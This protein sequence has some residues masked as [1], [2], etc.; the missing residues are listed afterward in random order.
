M[1][2]RG[3]R[4]KKSR[5]HV[6]DA[7]NVAGT[8]DNAEGSKVPK[9]LVIRRG[10]C[11]QVVGDLIQDMRRLMMPYTA[12]NF[13]ED[14]NYRKLTLSKYCQ[15]VC[16]PLGISHIMAFSQ[17]DERLSL[18]IA[19]TPQGPTLTFRVHLFSLTKHI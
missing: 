4:R 9:S 2:K 8:L 15:H 5:T 17:R 7:E 10:K 19:K 11:E 3:R 16:L 14:A 1:P 12:M 6:A 13:H 18:R